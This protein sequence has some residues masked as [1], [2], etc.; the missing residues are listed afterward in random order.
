ML[1]LDQACGEGL[2]FA[3][4]VL[5]SKFEDTKRVTVSKVLVLVGVGDSKVERFKDS[6]YIILVSHS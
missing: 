5:D 6:G 4:V 2:S 1:G 3:Q